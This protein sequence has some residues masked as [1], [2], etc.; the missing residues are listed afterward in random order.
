MNKAVLQGDSLVRQKVIFTANNISWNSIH[1]GCRLAIV[2]SHLFVS[3]GERGQRHSAQDGLSHGGSVV[4]IGLNGSI[5]KDN[6]SNDN[7]LPEL[8]T[9][10]HRNPQGMAI[11][12]KTGDIWVNEHGPKGGDE[13]NILQPG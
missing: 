4:R 8:L 13:I 1:F 12:P 5:P 9:K 11:H 2:D 3:L 10:G 7:W 6:Q